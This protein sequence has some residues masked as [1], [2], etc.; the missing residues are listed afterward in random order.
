M[1]KPSAPNEIRTRVPGLK[2]PCP[3]PLDDR[4]GRFDDILIVDLRF[5]S[6]IFNLLYVMS[7]M[8]LTILPSIHHI[9]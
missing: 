7:L 6:V 3:R 2:S 4:G 1:L 5:I 8:P 9:L